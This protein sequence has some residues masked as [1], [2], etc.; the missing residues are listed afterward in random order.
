MKKNTLIQSLGF[1]DSDHKNIKHDSAVHFIKIPHILLSIIQK[2]NIQFPTIVENELK[3]FGYELN[4]PMI[5]VEAIDVSNIFLETEAVLTKGTHRDNKYTIGFLDGILTFDVKYQGYGHKQLKNNEVDVELHEDEQKLIN[6]KKHLLYFCEN[7]SK[8]KCNKIFYIIECTMKIV[9]SDIFTCFLIFDGMEYYL[10]HNGV[11]I[12]K[13]NQMFT[14]SSSLTPIGTIVDVTTNKKGQ[15]IEKSDEKYIIKW[16]ND[17][18][19]RFYLY[20]KN[21]NIQIEIFPTLKKKPYQCGEINSPLLQIIS[22]SIYPTYIF[23]IFNQK[24]DLM[25][26]GSFQNQDYLY[27]LYFQS[28]IT[29]KIEKYYLWS[30]NKYSL[31]KCFTKQWTQKQILYK[32]QTQTFR[33][34][35]KFHP[36]SA[37]DIIRQIKLYDEYLTIKQPW[38]ILT[39]FPLS[40]L[41]QDELTAAKLHWIQLGGH[42][43]NLWFNA[44]QNESYQTALLTF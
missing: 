4:L 14:Y 26:D 5:N 3:G 32:T 29:H 37:S 24:Y 19:Y 12:N 1:S 38:L 23:D 35:T 34:E 25:E 20:N 33:I 7:G 22:P 36:T 44:K 30:Q 6:E 9:A 10:T 28:D 40:N 8:Q 15:I 43:F 18:C 13:K 41:E 21:D 11:F 2:L 31:I 39:F 27:Y 16:E 42:E 17:D